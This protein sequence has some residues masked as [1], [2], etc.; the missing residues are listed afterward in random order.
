MPFY[1]LNILAMPIH[2]TNSYVGPLFILIFFPDPNGFISAASGKVFSIV[3]PSNWL[4]F[5]FMTLK[6]VL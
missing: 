1:I 5:I 4:Y 6:L 3:A 2:L